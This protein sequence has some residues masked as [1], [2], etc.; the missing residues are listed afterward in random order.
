M[1]K[2]K[3]DAAV[4]LAERMLEVLKA[5]GNYGAEGDP[6]TLQEL[7]EHCDGAPSHELIV[8]AA[9]K[10]VF[11]D[12]AVVVDKVDK[13]PALASPVYFKGE[14]PKREVLL[15]RRMVAVLE[16]QRRL[17]DEAY[18]PTLRRLAQ[19][20][21]VKGP[22]AAIRKAAATDPMAS[23]TTVLAKNGNSLRPDAPVVFRE[24]IE[25]N[26]ATVLPALLRFALRPTTSK[27]KKGIRETAAFTVKELANRF[28]PEL[29]SRL[30][31]AVEEAIA[32]GSLPH[33]VA[34]ISKGD[35]L[36]FLVEH[37]RPAD[38][39]AT[40]GADA[41]ATPAHRDPAGDAPASNAHV[42]ASEFVQAFRAAFEDLDRRNGSTN[43]VKLSD[44]RSALSEFSREDFD[45]GLRRLRIEGV[46]SLDSHE[47]LHGSLTDDEREAGVREAGS[48]LIYASR[49]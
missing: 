25:G 34:W 2:K 7:G 35:P 21:E 3:P 28:I 17:G 13:K 12:K 40:T 6:P 11:T 30:T 20:C 45:A 37:L 43:F 27:T 29:R 18:P 49:R 48:V 10:K 33:G 42:P 36:L 5:K 8:K 24:E 4:E 47:G 38:S 23:R 19:L 31:D 39:R 16:S 46:F 32:R 15:A 14:V 26:L 1:G 9:T 44:L 22:D 41:Y